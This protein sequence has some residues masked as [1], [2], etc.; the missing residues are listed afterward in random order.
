[1]NSMTEVAL[2]LKDQLLSLSEEDRAALLEVLHD[3]LP[4]ELEEG[5][6]EAWEA[7][8]DRRF[9]EIEDGTAVGRPAQEAFDEIRRKYS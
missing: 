2:Q 6:H 8:L 7:E 1:V 3:S 4:E 9:K 5:Y